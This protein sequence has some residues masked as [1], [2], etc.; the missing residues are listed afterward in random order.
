[1]NELA[2]VFTLIKSLPSELEQSRTRMIIALLCSLTVCVLPDEVNS[3]CDSQ[4]VVEP[5]LL[6]NFTFSVFSGLPLGSRR[7]RKVNTSKMPCE[8]AVT[9]LPERHCKP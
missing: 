4:S 6:Q 2:E 1:M 3:L 8:V 9:V 7:L 5:D